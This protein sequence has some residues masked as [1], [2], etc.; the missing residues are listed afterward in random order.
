GG[1]QNSNLFLHMPLFDEIYY[2]GYHEGKVRK[3][4][5]IREEQ[6]CDL[7]VLNVI[8]KSEDILW[9][10]LEDLLK[11]SVSEAA[12]SVHG[13]Y[14]FDLLTMDI[15]KELKTYNHNELKTLLINS[16]LKLKPGEQKLIKYSSVYGL[17]QKTIHESWGKI[18]FKTAVEFFKDKSSYLDLLLRQLLKNFEFSHDPAILLL[19]DLSQ[20]PIFDPQDEV[21]QERLKKVIEKQIPASIEFPPEVYIQDKNGVRELLS[22]EVII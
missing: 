1:I 18:T 3:Y 2:E 15:H 12:F 7:L 5:A 20:T 10:A 4:K 16:A 11:R 9:D 21:Q 6:K 17:F 22:G 19:N 13:V 14:I 8:R